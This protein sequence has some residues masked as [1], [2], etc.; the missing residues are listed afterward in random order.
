MAIIW[1]YLETRIDTIY[2]DNI[3]EHLEKNCPDMVIPFLERIIYDTSNL[4]DLEFESGDVIGQS[5]TDQ[6]MNV[7]FLCFYDNMTKLH[8]G[9]VSDE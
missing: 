1:I 5:F 7:C 6:S 3:L 8:S 9:P 2:K 4:E